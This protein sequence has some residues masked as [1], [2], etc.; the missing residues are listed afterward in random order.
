M[1]LT[2]VHLI[3]VQLDL[4]IS[5]DVMLEGIILI[6]HHLSDLRKIIPTHHIFNVIQILEHVFHILFL[7]VN[8][9]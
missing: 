3:N 4:V 8:N 5:K 9:F 6:A 2:L 1:V 7:F